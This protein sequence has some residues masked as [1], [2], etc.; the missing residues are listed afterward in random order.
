MEGVK[1]MFAPKQEVIVSSH[2]HLVEGA[3]ASVGGVSSGDSPTSLSSS[4]G[5]SIVKPSK[6]TEKIKSLE[7]YASYEEGGQEGKIIVQV[8]LPVP[9]PT[10]SPGAEA[11]GV[12]G[13]IGGG[14]K[15]PSPFMALYRGDG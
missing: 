12:G 9:V 15:A 10:P 1:G 11:Q 4:G 5:P 8:P 2:S 14:S 13:G 3:A 7:S 6:S